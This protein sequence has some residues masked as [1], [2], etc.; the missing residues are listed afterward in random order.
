MKKG[1]TSIAVYQPHIP[2]IGVR[3]QGFPA[4]CV[5]DGLQFVSQDPPGFVPTDSLKQATSFF[6]LSDLRKLDAVVTMNA[7]VIISHL[8]A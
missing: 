3:K 8:S 1:I 4:I 6:S 7:L 2:G 5:L